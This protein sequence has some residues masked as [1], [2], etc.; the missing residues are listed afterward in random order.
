MSARR[1]AFCFWPRYGPKAIGGTRSRTAK[2]PSPWTGDCF[3]CKDKSIVIN[4]N[5][6]S[7]RTCTK[8]RGVV[9]MA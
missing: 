4:K 8:S 7:I 3:T 9:A 5:I 6:V 1:K 2:T